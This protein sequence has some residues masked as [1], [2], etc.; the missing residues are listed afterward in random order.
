MASLVEEMKIHL[1]KGGEE[2]VRIVA[3]HHTAVPEGDFEAVRNGGGAIAQED[4]EQPVLVAFHGPTLLT[5]HDG[6]GCGVGLIRA[7]RHPGHTVDGDWMSAQQVVRQ[8]GFASN[9][10]QRG[11][12]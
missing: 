12:G 9:E 5:E 10:P 2:P 7:N 11:I 1:A 4:R 6:D 8:G 3:Q